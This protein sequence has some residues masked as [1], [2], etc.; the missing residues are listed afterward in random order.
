MFNWEQTS[1]PPRPKCHILASGAAGSL[2]PKKIK[3]LTLAVLGAGFAGE[4]KGP[5]ISEKGDRSGS[6]RRKVRLRCPQKRKIVGQ[7]F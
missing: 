1:P 3:R 7:V 4:E 2:S 6:G 5:H